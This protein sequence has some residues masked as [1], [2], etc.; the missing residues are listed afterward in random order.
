M[1][2]TSKPIWAAPIENLP[3]PQ[4]KSKRLV[5]SFNLLNTFFQHPGV[6]LLN[7]K[8]SLPHNGQY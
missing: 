1:P 4:P 8:K 7:N 6:M 3:D 2:V 5:P